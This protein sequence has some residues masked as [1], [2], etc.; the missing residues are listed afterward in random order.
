MITSPRTTFRTRA[1]SSPTHS[2]SFY[3]LVLSVRMN[4]ASQR[5][6]K[7]GVEDTQGVGST[8]KRQTSGELKK[9]AR[10]Q[11]PGTNPLR[12]TSLSGW[13]LSPASL[14]K[15]EHSR[16]MVVEAQGYRTAL[17]LEEL[18]RDAERN[19]AVT[20]DEG[21][22]GIENDLP[23]RVSPFV[24]NTAACRNITMRKSLD[25]LHDDL[26]PRTPDDVAK[27]RSTRRERD[28]QYEN[29]IRFQGASAVSIEHI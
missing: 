24:S 22:A 5:D 21:R 16:R 9:A 23:T 8:T 13:P 12:S 18:K 2:L 14:T 29:E 10:R 20:K 7:T 17:R 4:R 28:V 15:L 6:G 27:R 3:L 25:R 19:D 11:S 1:L 26:P